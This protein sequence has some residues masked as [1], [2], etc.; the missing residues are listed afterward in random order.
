MKMKTYSFNYSKEDKMYV[1]TCD[2]YP[3]LSYLGHT[4]KETIKGIEKLVSDTENE[5]NS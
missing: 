5:I 1:G 4:L 2:K 3:S